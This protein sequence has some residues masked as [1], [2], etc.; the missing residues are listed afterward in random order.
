MRIGIDV[1]GGDNAPLE[2]IKGAALVLE[3]IDTNIKIVLFGDNT[4]I[5]T[6]CKENSIDSSQFDI[7]HTTEIIEMHE[8]PAKAFQGKPDSSITKGFE[9]LAHEKIDAFA[10]VGNTGAMLVGAMMVIK[11]LEGVIRP[12]LATVLPKT[13]GK[14][15]ILLDVGIN[16]DCKPEVLLQYGILGSIYASE[17]YGIKNPKVGLLNIGSEEGKG[18]QLA[19]STYDLMK[20]TK[21]FNFIGNIEGSDLF[22]SD[23]ADVVVTDGFT[24][25]IVL[26]QSESIYRL[27]KKRNIDDEYFNRFNFE[28]YGGTPVLGIN[29]TVVIG[30]G[31]SKAMAIKNMILHT[32]DI[33]KAKMGRKIAERLKEN[34]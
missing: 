25:N 22:R 2:I 21:A 11:P 33:E 1:M 13:D 18:N 32:I 34:K 4:Q 7:V 31:V 24:G 6:I 17:V 23:V 27:T 26:K 14:D 3:N 28:L 5:K 16:P 30:H 12:C 10:S 20:D 29:R 9:Y 15:A 8:H 19:R